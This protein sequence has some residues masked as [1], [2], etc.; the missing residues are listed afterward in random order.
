MRAPI[1][2]E[3]I[4]FFCLTNLYDAT[5][6]Q[7]I[8]MGVISFPTDSRIVDANAQPTP[9]DIVLVGTYLQTPAKIT[10]DNLKTLIQPD[11]SGILSRLD[12]L[13]AGGGADVVALKSALRGLSRADA[14]AMGGSSDPLGS[15]ILLSAMGVGENGLSLVDSNGLL[16]ISREYSAKWVGGVSAGWWYWWVGL[17]DGVI[18]VLASKTIG[19]PVGMSDGLLICPIYVQSTTLDIAGFSL[20]DGVYRGYMGGEAVVQSHTVLSGDVYAFDFSAVPYDPDRIIAYYAVSDSNRYAGGI[21]GDYPSYP[22]I[23]RLGDG[24]TWGT[25]YPANI[26]IYPA[27]YT[28]SVIIRNETGNDRFLYV[29]PS[30]FR[31]RGQR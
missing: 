27:D 2:N 3:S 4:S 16:D 18:D 24:L 1:H 19:V 17:V 14:Y 8:I 29:W 21:I 28:G 7:C 22:E 6:T 9:L 20:R 12:A 5:V 15:A 30:H 13:E 25:E 26:K 10:G 31:V 11:L 23:E